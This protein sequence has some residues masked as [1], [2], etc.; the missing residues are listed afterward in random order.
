MRKRLVK[1]PWLCR[2]C[3]TEAR[4]PNGSSH[5]CV[6]GLTVSPL[7]VKKAHQLRAKG[8]KGLPVSCPPCSHQYKG[9]PPL[10]SGSVCPVLP[11]FLVVKVEWEGQKVRNSPSPLF[12]ELPHNAKRVDDP[13]DTFP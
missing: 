13:S 4:A 12:T 3:R 2:D 10:F 7:L 6:T 11:L 8:E 9:S 1:S 5:A